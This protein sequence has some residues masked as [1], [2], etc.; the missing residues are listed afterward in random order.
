MKKIILVLVLSVMSATAASACLF[1]DT[2]IQMAR[3]SDLQTGPE[4]VLKETSKITKLQSKQLIQAFSKEYEEK[5][6]M[7][8]IFEFADDGVL[9]VRS[10][11]DTRNYKTYTMYLYAA[12][13]TVCGYIFEE[14]TLKQVAVIGD[15]SIYKCTVSFN[16]YTS[17]PWFY[18]TK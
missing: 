8:K 9:Y 17:L 7:K 3:M 14:K 16:R 6:T 10:V 18:Q 1:G 13:D 5:F 2:L 15:G 4:I 11:F 12:G